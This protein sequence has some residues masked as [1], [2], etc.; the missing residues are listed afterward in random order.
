[1][2][3][4]E[5]TQKTENPRKTNASTGENKNR[6]KEFEAMKKQLEILSKALEQQNKLNNSIDLDEDVDVIST[7]NGTLNLTTGGFGRG[8]IY[9]FIEFGQILPIPFRDLKEIVKNNRSF[10][11]KGFFYIDN[12]D[13]MVAL[14]V[15]KLCEKLPTVEELTNILKK[16][17]QVAKKIL[18]MCTKEQKEMVASFVVEKLMHNE[19]IDMNLVKVI[20]DSVDEDLLSA[21]KIKKELVSGG[22]DK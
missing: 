4:I 6:D 13:A 17:V 9:K 21:S 16:D 1:M 20:G 5:K 15:A 11:A 22:G 8:E 3:Q 12:S 18:K 10:L 7:C 19:N 14:R 2:T